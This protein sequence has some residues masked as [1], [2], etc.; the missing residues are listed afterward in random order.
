MYSKTSAMKW[1]VVFAMSVPFGTLCLAQETEKETKQ[2][3]LTIE[4]AIAAGVEQLL[5]IQNDDGCWPYEGVYRVNQK[6]PVG[7]RIGGTAICCE[8]LMYATSKDNKKANLAIQRGV[9]LILKELE[10]PLMKPSQEDVYD[11]RVWGHI[12]A[13]DLFC[14]LKSAQRCPELESRYVPWI[15]TLTTTLLHEELKKGGWN[16]ANHRVHAAF[17]TAP[18][19]QSLLWAHQSGH[20]IPSEVFNRAKGAFER[21]RNPEGA[22]AY[23]G[24]ISERRRAKLPGSIARSAVSE[25]TLQLLGENRHEEIGDAIDAFHVHWDELEKRRKKSGTHKPPYGVAPYYFYYGHRYAAQSIQGLP[26]SARAEQF[27]KFNAVLMKTR[28]EDGTWNDRV[29]PRS[30]AYGTAMSILALLGD[31]VPLP[32]RLKEPQK[33]GGEFFDAKKIDVTF[34]VSNT[35]VKIDGQTLEHDEVEIWLQEYSKSG[36]MVSVLIEADRATKMQT[37][38]LVSDLAYKHLKVK[39]LFVKTLD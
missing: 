33:T 21:S 22:Y 24:D 37:V 20:E 6:I 30:R 17:V 9:E 25:L 12:Y 14:R 27:Q 32:K 18:A 34:R 28:D 35:D 8:A 13:L 10:H 29:F 38:I 1:F 5:A 26:E 11:V 15:E 23:S 36:K 19:V 4:G 3:E 31:K 2:A 7:Y 16:Y 39:K